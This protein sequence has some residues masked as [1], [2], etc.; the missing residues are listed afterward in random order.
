MET[1][2]VEPKKRLRIEMGIRLM[3]I[4]AYTVIFIGGVAAMFFTPNSIINELVGYEWLIPY[5][6]LMLLVGGGLGFFARVSTIWIME[7][8][9]DVISMFGIV[10][11]FF[12]LGKTAFSSLTAVLASCLIMVSLL[13]VIRRYLELQLFGSNPDHRDFRSKLR[14]ALMRRIPN[15]PPRG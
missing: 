10:I 7:P 9:A 13:F 3:D 2:P 8:A 4:F 5:W 15:V 11:Y 12:V 14:D 6:A 1:F